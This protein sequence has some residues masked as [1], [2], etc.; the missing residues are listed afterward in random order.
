MNSVFTGKVPTH[1]TKL[2]LCTKLQVHPT[3]YQFLHKQHPF[4]NP[5]KTRRVRLL[6]ATAWNA[7]SLY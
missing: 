1:A 5:H 3:V 2:R 4:Q 6:G 7:I